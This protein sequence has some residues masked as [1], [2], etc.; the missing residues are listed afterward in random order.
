M[1]Y[2][3]TT[4]RTYGKS[5]YEK[6]DKGWAKQ[7]E[8]K[9]QTAQSGQ[10][11][12]TDE[13]LAGFARKASDASLKKAGAG[14][15]ERMRIAA[16]K[17]LLRRQSE[18]A[19]EPAPS[20]NP[21]D[22]GMQKGLF[23]EFPTRM[24]GETEYINKG[25]GWEVLE[26]GRG[27]QI[28]EIRDWKGGKYQKTANGWVPYTQGGGASAKKEG[29]GDS[30]DGKVLSMKKEL[31]SLKEEFTRLQNNASEY[32]KTKMSDEDCEKFVRA[33]AGNKGVES[34][35][36]ML[37]EGF[38]ASMASGLI[39][40]N[41]NSDLMKKMAKLYKDVWEETGEK[42]VDMSTNDLKKH[43]EDAEKAGSTP[44]T[45]STPKGEG[46][47]DLVSDKAKKVAMATRERVL[48]TPAWR[49]KDN[50]SRKILEEARSNEAGYVVKDNRVWVYDAGI[51][52]KNGKVR[53]SLAPYTSISND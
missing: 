48:N 17:E 24:F 23:D 11:E 39:Y 41:A 50:E 25:Q 5:K 44:K 38:N 27:A 10:K 33:I 32:R 53:I 52:D 37:E 45:D 8:E 34:F 40:N 12:Y 6:T 26:K 36:S 9:Q 19:S 7:V 42:L 18:G 16:K 30:S 4:F 49:V 46:A 15:N 51:P 31:L 43:I 3:D 20:E 1:S 22:D 29:E 13:E 28:G 47:S 2:T 35:K 14:A 21:F